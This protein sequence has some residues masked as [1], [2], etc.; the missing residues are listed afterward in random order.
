M[1]SN[2]YKLAL[3]FKLLFFVLYAC[4]NE[5][6][7]NHTY[8]RETSAHSNAKQS[9]W[10]QI[11]PE[12]LDNPYDTVGINY[13]AFVEDLWAR[14]SIFTSLNFIITEVNNITDFTNP[15]AINYISSAADLLLIQNILDDSEQVFHDILS[16]SGLSSNAGDAITEIINY[17]TLNESEDYPILYAYIVSF[18]STILD[19]LTFSMQEKGSK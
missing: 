1:Y 3:S 8:E 2:Y 10:G 14:D 7:V 17:T 16:Q 5:D 13:T 4:L 12:N 19:D 9:K 18:E 15:I 11:S 6:D